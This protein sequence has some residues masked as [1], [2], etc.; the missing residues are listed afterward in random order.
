MNKKEMQMILDA[1]ENLV[2]FWPH[3]ASKI[4]MELVDIE[5]IKD[6]K[7]AIRALR[8]AL[9]QP[10]QE[11]VTFPDAPTTIYL[12]VCDDMDCKESF[13]D[14]PDV[15][16]CEDQINDSDIKYI[17]S[18]IFNPNLDQIEDLQKCLREHMAEIQR[19]RKE[20]TQPEKTCPPC[21]QNCNQGRTCPSR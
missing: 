4:N 8:Q 9:A 14:H 19:L 12:Q 18:D 6:A 13:Y 5:A 16:W 11:P 20:L 2:S 17:R 21:N 10:E 3:Y 7:K 1:F 15:S